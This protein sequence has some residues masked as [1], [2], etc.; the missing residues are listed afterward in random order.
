M[1]SSSGIQ[2]SGIVLNTLLESPI[3]HLKLAEPTGDRFQDE[4]TL[5]AIVDEVG[6]QGIKLFSFLSSE[7]LIQPD[8]IDVFQ[9]S[10]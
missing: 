9:A 10:S 2:Q 3:V 8:L 4:K 1:F 6:K 7:I 5:Q